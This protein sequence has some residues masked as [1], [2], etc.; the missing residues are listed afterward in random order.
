MD[1]GSFLWARLLGINSTQELRRPGVNNYK[2]MCYCL[3]DQ[4]DQ[5]RISCF[6]SEGFSTAPSCIVDYLRLILNLLMMK[7][8]MLFG[9][10]PNTFPSTEFR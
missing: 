3:K 4:I 2:Y 5:I 9:G 7:L 1:S 8:F 6:I 10:S